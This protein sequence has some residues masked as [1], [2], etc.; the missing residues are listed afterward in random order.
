MSLRPWLSRH[1]WGLRVSWV[2]LGALCLG[3][4]AGFSRNLVP[5]PRGRSLFALPF[6]LFGAI[7]LLLMYETWFAENR[8]GALDLLLRI[9]FGL[10]TGGYLVAVVLF[11]WYF[12]L[13]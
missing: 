11:S 1:K 5:L 9:F 4:V 8:V 6:F 12:L 3:L 10:L 2:I 13:H 7:Q